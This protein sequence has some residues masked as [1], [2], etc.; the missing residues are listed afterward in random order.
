MMKTALSVGLAAALLS[1]SIGSALARSVCY[2]DP[3]NGLREQVLRIA[4]DSSSLLTTRRE[5]RK[6]GADNPAQLVYLARGLSIEDQDIFVATGTLDGTVVVGR[7][8]GAWMGLTFMHG[9]F[10]FD[11]DDADLVQS[12]V[13]VSKEPSPTPN[14]W[15]CH[16]MRGSSTRAEIRDFHRVHRP[17]DY[18]DC[19]LFGGIDPSI[20]E[21]D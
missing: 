11:P 15:R 21:P 5:Q 16:I 3:G 1:S 8:A 7:G 19:S 20:G 4:V 17:A 18:P 13:C 14:T 6:W 12:Y 2:Q 10:T 9:N